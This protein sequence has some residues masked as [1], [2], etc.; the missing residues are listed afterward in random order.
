M[1]FGCENLLEFVNYGDKT[2]NAALIACLVCQKLF[3]T[4]R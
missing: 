3:G 2:F 4:L 1:F